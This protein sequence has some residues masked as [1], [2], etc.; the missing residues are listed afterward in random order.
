M[1]ERRGAL[2]AGALLGLLTAAGCGDGAAPATAG[3][4]AG[5]L[6]TVPASMREC[7]QCHR[8]VVETFLRHGMA[9][10]LG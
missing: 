5:E 6:A 3:A 9:D 8:R 1:S 2:L 4:P 10:S 7:H